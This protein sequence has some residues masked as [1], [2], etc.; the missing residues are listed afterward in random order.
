MSMTIKE[1]KEIISNLP[2]E[3][4]ILIEETDINEVETIDI[5]YH[6]DG[7]THLIFSTLE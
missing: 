4:V 6:S 1:L 7:R 5:Q 2:N 3:T